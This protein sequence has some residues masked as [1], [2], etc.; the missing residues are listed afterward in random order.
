MFHVRHRLYVVMIEGVTEQ[1][2][3]AVSVRI[4]ALTL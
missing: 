2:E 3:L 4:I 1:P